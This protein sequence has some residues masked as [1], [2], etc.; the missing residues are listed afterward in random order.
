MAAP[1]CSAPRVSGL[2]T[3]LCPRGLNIQWPFSQLLLAGAKIIE[4]RGYEL[5]YRNIAQAAEETWIVETKGPSAVAST[6]AVFSGVDVPRRPDAAQIV[7]TVTF[8]RSD[9]YTDV[10]S[11]RADA[12][13]HCVR[14]GG[15]HDWSGEGS[16]HAWEI[17]SVRRLA[18]PVLVGCTGRTGFSHPRTGTQ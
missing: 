8:S 17:R 2:V 5:G 9:P 4:A 12:T 11:F 13:R 10:E 3:T 1:L 18:V 15:K 6:E 7:G 16:M 14:E